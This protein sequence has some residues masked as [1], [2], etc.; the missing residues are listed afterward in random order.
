MVFQGKWC[1]EVKAGD[2]FG[3]S[4]TVTETR[5]VLAAGMYFASAAT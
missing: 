1:D 4:L 3:D 5:L 2:A